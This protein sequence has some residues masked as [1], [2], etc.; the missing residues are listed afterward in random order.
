MNT[1]CA[2]A[3]ALM[4]RLTYP[5]KFALIGLLFAL[6]LAVALLLL[7]DN[8]NDT[9]EFTE[10]ELAG[11]VYLRP[12]RTLQ[13]D[14][15]QHRG[16]TSLAR[17]SRS[18]VSQPE[19]L[20]L[21]AQ[22]D[23]DLEGVAEADQALGQTFVTTTRSTALWGWWRDLR[24]TG[25][26]LSPQKNYDRHTELIA[27]V[28][29]LM[30][31]VGDESNLILDPDLDRY[32]LM[33]SVVN[34][35][36]A[37]TEQ[38]GRAR[39]WVIV[40]AAEERALGEPQAFRTQGDQI[41]T[42]LAGVRRN[43]EVVFR[44]KPALRPQLE[45]VLEHSLADTRRFLDLL[46]NAAGGAE[47]RAVTT[48]E[49][50]DKG[51]AAIAANF[52]L[53]DATIPVL[54]EA[55]QAHIDKYARQKTIT[56]VV[57]GIIAVIL[58]YLL[59]AFYLAVMRTVSSLDEVSKRLVA[60]RMDEADLLVETKDELGQVTRAFGALAKRLRTEWTQARSEAARAAAAES[61]TRLLID[62]AMDA[63]VV[64][65]AEG[66]IIDWNVQAE[67]VFGRP[68]AEALGRA[69][70][71]TIVPVRFRDA[72]EFVLRRIQSGNKTPFLNQRFEITGLHR[73]G[74]EFP[75][76]ISISPVRSGETVTY[77]TFIRDITDRKQAEENIRKSEQNFRA[78]S[79]S[80]PIGVFEVTE[81]GHCIYKNR[82]FES[83]FGVSVLD[84]PESWVTWFHGDERTALDQAWTRTKTNQSTISKDCR[85]ATSK[86]QDRWVN[87]QLS[88]MLSDAGL[89]YLGT[90]EDI[91]E[92]KRAEEALSQAAHEMEVKNRELAQ[93]R[94]AALE[95]ARLKSEFLAT[96]SHE[97][98]TPMNG[99][100]G[101]TSLLLDSDLTGEQREFAE[102]VR[103]SGDNL[104]TIINDILDFSKIEAGK[105]SL[106]IIAFDLRTAVEETVGMFAER[107][108]SK[109]LELACLIHSDVPTALRGDPGRVRQVLTNL[110][111]NAIKF[112]ERGEVVVTVEAV[113]ETPPLCKGRLGGVEA[114][115]CFD[116][117]SPLLTKE[118][119]RVV[120]RF[121]V[122]DSGIGITPE[123]RARLFQPFTQ[124]DGSTT[125]KY[126]GTGLGLA[127][128]RQL[129]ELMG[130]EI[131]VESEPGNGSTFWFTAKFE[132]QP[133][134]CRGGSRTAPTPRDHVDLQGA[135]VLIVDDN[136]T[137]RQILEVS[138]RNW[139]MAV[140]SA[141]DGPQALAQLRSAA[142]AGIP[143]DLAILDMQMPGMD[144]LALARAIK[145][146]PALAA[147]RLVLLTSFGRRGDGEEARK[148]G[149]AAYLTKPV[150]QSHLY[151]C[152]RTVMGRT[153]ASDPS[154]GAVREPLLQK[155]QPA[156]GLVTR[157]TLAE[158]AARNLP[159]IL[160]AEDNIINQK[161][162]VRILEKLG[163]RADV[164]ANGLEALDAVSRIRYAA[165]LMDCQMPEMDGF[166]AT[167]KI[168]EKECT[169]DAGHRPEE[170]A[171]HRLAPTT[172][173]PIIAVTA[174]AMKG[175]DE[176]CLA[177]GMDDY[178]SK[179]VT[180]QG[181]ETV[182]R[183]WVP[184]GQDMDSPPPSPSP[185]APVALQNA[186]GHGEGISGCPPAIDTQVLDGLRKLGGEEDPGFLV[187]L[188]ERFLKDAPSRLDEIRKA[189]E[190]GDAQA[191]EQTAHSLKG[192]CSTL[193][194][195]LMARLC[196]DLQRLGRGG[197][198]EG[199][200]GLCASLEAELARV[201]EALQSVRGSEKGSGT[202]EHLPT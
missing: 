100:L 170:R 78:L 91:T 174:N 147:T 31:Q 16:L 12:L 37:L 57:T 43:F 172:R 68:R 190:H 177:A 99:V 86:G 142:E 53:Y 202:L 137:N 180:P 21:E 115:P 35:L 15:Q 173:I 13:E 129:T 181:L 81:A 188:I 22:I 54:D 111:G 67:A 158:T 52:Q 157:H 150:R 58:F 183:R 112:T 51:S 6:P 201:Q 64:I 136:H 27:D 124:A 185:G 29:V 49:Y 42:L 195:H 198:L 20:A 90:I 120:L 44:V 197:S 77:S 48:E 196:G 9:I 59:V 85:F 178:L 126:G 25:S 18:P 95:A 84:C 97:I 143:C 105:M 156:P 191:L 119:N 127:I 161:V 113:A 168:R 108:Q 110:T 36:P 17:T 73:N 76:E 30:V 140:V 152:L 103:T 8:I 186:T 118:G 200:T 28:T 134:D 89:R 24:A 131:G 56:F 132:E 192:T 63:V 72:N 26:G 93:A 154:V 79:E 162:A 75:A 167:R 33:D 187:T 130:G 107:A 62:T 138:L 2:P 50:W 133:A 116:L 169:G 55:L 179:P 98:R 194:A 102:A 145:A 101:M 94:D 171:S 60:G 121:S 149:I 106:E 182:L 163:Y 74:L 82:A 23:R 7:L 61:K 34:K 166:E 153:P 164:A 155:N 69:L 125:R 96:M 165:I 160:V 41:E 87:L 65:D 80:L 114:E 3:I 175:D 46:K 14:L 66:L 88:P 19:L 141:P 117:P 104:L 47:R 32:Y 159:R 45:P 70:A 10:K 39:G 135:R 139:G 4:N 176:K 38:I 151:E 189:A 146:D 1:V 71:E 148:A 92:R 122:T 128:C 144:G 184:R 83:I 193:G 11:T 5:K 123:T 40:A 109:G 199:V